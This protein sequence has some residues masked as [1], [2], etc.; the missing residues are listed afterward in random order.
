M[1]TQCRPT[2]HRLL[3]FANA[4][5]LRKA[6]V[7]LVSLLSCGIAYAQS[8]PAGY[9]QTV[10]A[11][12]SHIESGDLEGAHRMLAEARR[13]Y[14]NDGG[15]EN[16]SGVV[17]VQQGNPVQAR[18]DFT[19]AIRHNPKLVG[20]Y[21]NLGRLDL[22]SGDNDPARLSEALGVYESALKI[23]PQ[24]AEANY[25]AATILTSR[26]KYQQSLNHLASLNAAEHAKVTVQILVCADEAAL[27]H[28]A[29]ADKS[30]SLLATDHDLTEEDVTLILPALK[31]ARRADLI[32]KLLAAVNAR[33]PLSASG[34]R[35]LG[36][37][38]EAD[39]KLVLS[40]STLEKAFSAN[41][42]L[43]APLLD[44]A[45][46]ARESKDDMG[47]LGY[48]A[49]ARD[50][51]PKDASIPFQFG[52][53]CAQ[54]NLFTESEK[55]LTEAVKLAPD[56]PLYNLDLGI[57]IS[58]DHDPTQALPYL[59]KFVAL[60]PDDPAGPLA[61]ATAYFRAKDYES[62]EPWLTRAA[63]FER[64][65]ASANYYLGR[66]AREKGQLHEAVADLTKSDRLKPDQPEV[67]AELGQIYVQLKRFEE[68]R[69][70]LLRALKIDANN[71][72]ANFGLLQLYVRTD[73]PRRA[74]QTKRFEAVKD[75]GEQESR[76]M[77]RVIE[78]SRDGKRDPE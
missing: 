12:Q 39:G 61:I 8:F 29:A 50:L 66:I 65:A 7:L 62:A 2:I 77:M 47:A 23:E 40:R 31:A 78:V 49:H 6:P 11:I 30:A 53:I 44:L 59:K 15:L 54:M 60:R 74:E 33:R 37:A 67:L 18:R 42:H 38:E 32:E 25:E 76:E 9:R 1:R 72:A 26:G 57:V 69:A 41:P 20:A 13:T 43:V 4:N 24:N 5:A 70:E 35:T 52:M 71:Y 17:E 27:G 51:E 22:E 16:L 28:R 46:I 56:D 3:R 10:L 73:D 21:L 45:R 14:A 34:L 55:A 64:T 36:L 75:Q 68:A 48:L 63:E 19:D 58:Y